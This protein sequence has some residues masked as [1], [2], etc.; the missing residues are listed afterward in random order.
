M[1]NVKQ[2]EEIRTKFC[3]NLTKQN[4]NT[5]IPAYFLVG[6]LRIWDCFTA[7]KI[8]AAN[9]EPEFPKKWLSLSFHLVK[10]APD[11]VPPEPLFSSFHK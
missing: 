11:A 8:N 4:T 10:M 1:T 6:P 3:K 7:L 9:P 5:E 2:I